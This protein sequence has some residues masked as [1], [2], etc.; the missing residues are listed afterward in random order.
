MEQSLG[1]HLNTNS[2]CSAVQ[3]PRASGLKLFHNKHTFDVFRDG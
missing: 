3:P 1:N 2:H